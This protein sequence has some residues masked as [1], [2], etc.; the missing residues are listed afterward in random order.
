MLTEVSNTKS[1]VSAAVIVIYSTEPV[2][3]WHS[4]SLNPFFF[5]NIILA[6]QIYVGRVYSLTESVLN[7]SRRVHL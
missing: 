6:E 4:Y 7:S 3:N 5:Y 1:Q 2:P